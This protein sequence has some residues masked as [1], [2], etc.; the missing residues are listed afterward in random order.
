M[1]KKTVCLKYVFLLHKLLRLA[2]ARKYCSPSG[3]MLVV[4]EMTE[5]TERPRFRYMIEFPTK[6]RIYAVDEQFLS[7]IVEKYGML[8]NTASSSNTRSPWLEKRHMTTLSNISRCPK[9]ASPNI[10]LDNER[11]KVICTSCGLEIDAQNQMENSEKPG[12]DSILTGYKIRENKKGFAIIRQSKKASYTTNISRSTVEEIYRF[13][14]N[15]GEQLPA[16]EIYRA[17]DISDA[18]TYNALRV[19]EA[20]GRVHVESNTGP[21]RKHRL[22]F[23]AI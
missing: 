13:L 1:L 5:E 7:S 12:L 6:I 4:A 8:V 21:G 3:M 22:L 16:C 11:A 18:S 14:K 15:N 23:K 2:K 20:H 19:L 17:L 9:C 10:V